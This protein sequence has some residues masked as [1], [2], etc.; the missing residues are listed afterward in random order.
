M[1]PPPG[2]VHA[3]TDGQKDLAREHA[4]KSLK[5]LESDKTLDERRRAAIRASA[6]RKLK[7]LGAAR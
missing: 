5:L 4:E 1:M 2:D 6:E 7:E 3:A